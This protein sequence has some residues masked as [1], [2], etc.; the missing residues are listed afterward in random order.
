MK[1]QISNRVKKFLI[2]SYIFLT[3]YLWETILLGTS[4]EPIV[5]WLFGLF[6]LACLVYAWFKLYKKNPALVVKLSLS[7]IFTILIGYFWYEAWRWES[8]V[9]NDESAWYQFP[10]QSRLEI[11]MVYLIALFKTVAVYC[12]TSFV[13]RCFKIGNKI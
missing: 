3:L 2:F 7:I 4:A 1:L 9:V 10:A 5:T 11:L 13:L 8:M 6:I 12:V